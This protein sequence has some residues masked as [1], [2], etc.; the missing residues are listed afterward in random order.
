VDGSFDP[1]Q[2]AWQ[3]YL[4][5][6][7][8]ED[9]DATWTHHLY[10]Q[11]RDQVPTF[12]GERLWGCFSYDYLADRRTIGLHFSHQDTSGDGPLSQQRRA[13]RM[14][15]LRAMFGHIKQAHP[16][17]ASVA[18]GSWLYNRE[19]YR[20]LFPASYIGSARVGIPGFSFRNI[21]GQFMR[22]DWQ[23]YEDLA[24]LFLKRVGQL[25]DVEHALECFP[26]QVL[27]VQGPIE[28]FYAF[29]GM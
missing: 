21:W 25:R 8:G 10:L 14:D 17:A 2:A 28:D 9:S 1:D 6:L 16:D 12:N 23:V 4:R 22:H 15:E 3:A 19:A 24:A 26:Y 27:D 20:R 13:M 29:H 7:R 11:R 5:G 18:G